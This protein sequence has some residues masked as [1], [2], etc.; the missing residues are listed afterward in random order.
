[1][2]RGSIS[3]LL[4]AGDACW[5]LEGHDIKAGAEEEINYHYAAEAPET[6]SKMTKL[7][8]FFFLAAFLPLFA[9]GAIQ[10]W[11]IFFLHKPNILEFS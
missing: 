9:T 7:T 8:P 3:N 1:L 10:V 11:E 4:R 5:R 6:Q 2:T